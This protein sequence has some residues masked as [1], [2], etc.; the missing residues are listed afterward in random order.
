[1]LGQICWSW[2]VEGVR[3]VRCRAEGARNRGVRC[4]LGLLALWGTPWVGLSISLPVY[5]TLTSRCPVG[6]IWTQLL[7]SEGLPSLSVDSPFSFI[8]S[9]CKWLVIKLYLLFY[10]Q[11]VMRPTNNVQSLLVTWWPP[12]MKSQ[13]AWALFADRFA[14]AANDHLSCIPFWLS[15]FISKNATLWI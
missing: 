1:M 12:S 14:N 10:N 4:L 8:P 9:S 7:P 6:W 11:L 2:S 5:A 15:F 3:K 13:S